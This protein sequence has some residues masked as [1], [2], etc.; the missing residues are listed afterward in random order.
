MKRNKFVYNGKGYFR[1]GA[2]DV[3]LASYGNKKAGP[4]KANYLDVAGEVPP[5]ALEN[6]KVIA[7]E[8]SLD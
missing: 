2:E 6:A 4:L 8:V 7:T 5:D 3:T 1:T